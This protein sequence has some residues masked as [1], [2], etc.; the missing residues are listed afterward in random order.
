MQDPNALEPGPLTLDRTR[1]SAALARR[2]GLPILVSGGELPDLHMTL[3]AMM[4]QSL[5][6]DFGLDAKWQ[7]DR[8]RDTWEN[9][10]FTTTIL[11]QAG[12]RR[13]YLV[14]HDWHMRRS[15]LAFQHFGLDPVPVSVRPPFAPPL[16][17]RRF[18]ITPV[19]WFN[20]YIAIHEWVGLAYYAARR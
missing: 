8:S 7:E 10:E 12:V 4:A 13:I 18:V 1:A 15:L 3:A 6:E 19:A 16:S 17:W 11:R 5:H 14:T 20:S 2:T 9:A